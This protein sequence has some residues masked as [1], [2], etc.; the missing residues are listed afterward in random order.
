LNEWRALL[1]RGKIKA[2]GRYTAGL[3]MRGAFRPYCGR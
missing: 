3:G 1:Q 2:A